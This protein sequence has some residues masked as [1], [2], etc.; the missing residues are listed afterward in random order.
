MVQSD[1]VMWM[2]MFILALLA[3]VVLKET[4]RV[5]MMLLGLEKDLEQEGKEELKEL[6]EMVLL[7][8]MRK[9]RR[10]RH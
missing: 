8:L 9:S 10:R 4:A 1:L 3:F 5:H 6:L 7:T 2:R